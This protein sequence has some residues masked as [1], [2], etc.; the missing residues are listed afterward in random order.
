MAKHVAGP[1]K[2]R[3]GLARGAL[4]LILWMV[5]IGVAPGD[6]AVGAAAALLAGWTSLALLPAGPGRLRPVALARYFLHFLWQSLLGSWDVAC[7]AFDPRLPLRPGFVIHETALPRG[8]ARNAFASLT[9]LIPGTLPVEDEGD[10]LV[11]HC[12]D[13]GQPVAAQL[14]TEEAAFIRALGFLPGQEDAP[15]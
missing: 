9:S 5:L 7:R 3:P 10:A 12:L 1:S 15:R 6:L 8:P 2:L 14:A 13:V 11:F 4:F